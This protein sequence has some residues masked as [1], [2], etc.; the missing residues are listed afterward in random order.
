MNVFLETFGL[1]K[2]RDSVGQLNI[3][4][5]QKINDILRTTKGKNLCAWVIQCSA[6]SKL[7]TAELKKL[8]CPN[9]MYLCSDIGIQYIFR[10]WL[11]ENA[12]NLMLDMCFAAT[13]T[14]LH[15]D[16]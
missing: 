12:L 4:G 3:I 5:A 13:D 1:D 10:D 8:R 2:M 16:S 15:A 9:D 6:H 11:L 14:A 7:T